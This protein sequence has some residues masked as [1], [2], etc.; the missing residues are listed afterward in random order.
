MADF[1]GLLKRTI[2]AQSNATPELRQRI[3]DRA[4]ETVEKKLAA[5]NVAPEVVEL[6]R[7]IMEKAINEVEELCREADESVKLFL[8]EQEEPRLRME[9][10]AGFRD[11][12]FAFGRPDV[13]VDAGND[14][15]EEAPFLKNEETVPHFDM[16]DTGEPDFI[17][18]QQETFSGAMFAL[19]ESAD[20]EEQSADMLVDNLPL[21]GDRPDFVDNAFPSAL[22]ALSVD[23][24]PEDD[25]PPF[26]E[27]GAS[28]GS[29]LFD[30]GLDTVGEAV[31][32][33]AGYKGSISAGQE[34]VYGNEA[35]ASFEP[36]DMSVP[37]PASEPEMHNDR[38][39][40]PVPDF[41]LNDEETSESP[42]FYLDEEAVSHDGAEALLADFAVQEQE[43]MEAPAFMGGRSVGE[44]TELL[45]DASFFAEDMESV[46]VPVSPAP[47]E[48]MEPLQAEKQARRTPAD[49]PPLVPEAEKP[50]ISERNDDFS[51]VSGIF[52]QAAIRE[53]KRS[54][55]KRLL[56]AGAIIVVILCIIAAI[57]WFLTDFL[58]EEESGYSLSV[59]EAQVSENAMRE[60]QLE[61]I[62]HRLMSD[63]Q[64][65]NPGP[66]KGF[67]M[68]GEGTSTTTASRPV[69]QTAEAVFHE[70]QTAVLPEILETG[71][72][73][74]SL[75]HDKTEDGQEDMAI[76]GDVSIPGKDIMLR[77]TIR[78]NNDPSIP[79]AYL[80]ELIFIVP[81]NFDGM[82]IDRVG[83]LLFKASE[84]STGQDLHGMV[85]FKIDDNFFILA[86]SASKP[87]LS[88][89]LN[90]MRQ[91]PWMKLDIAY[92]NGRVGEFS[93][94]K[95]EAG[96]AVFKQMFDNIAESE[97]R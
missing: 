28:G 89:N 38:E 68:P 1:V 29:A 17:S 82:A 61:K 63:G 85:P 23:T 86:I 31:E 40:Q 4:R 11:M 79:A 53:K 26:E 90:I 32:T 94:A 54:G 30:I 35:A 70:S 12:P 14:F 73:K 36:F 20:S 33:G 49:I 3:Y 5:S 81:E 27:D 74:W 48:D 39:F 91:L 56:T 21:S 2:D 93:L 84:Q 58:R 77:M 65:T 16:P 80:I 46:R 64:E 72:V 9:P 76:R 62:T 22:D 41:L 52:A 78:R 44:E 95:G 6:Q 50:A 69:S 87:F 19:P 83:P 55:K 59:S 96:D 43:V 92:K 47:L 71:T 60:K 7:T 13:S 15:L 88:R 67:E 51:V 45:R 10:R 8:E 66:A 18:E 37:F 75:L 34:L 57:I 24:S 97:N 25:F 42:Q